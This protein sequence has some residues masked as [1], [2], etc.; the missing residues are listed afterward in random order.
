MLVVGSR[1]VVDTPGLGRPSETASS[2]NRC[3]QVWFVS[4]IFATK[5][6]LRRVSG[7]VSVPGSVYVLAPHPPAALP[8]SFL[9][10]PRVAAGVYGLYRC[11]PDRCRLGRDGRR[12]R[13][14]T[15]TKVYCQRSAPVWVSWT[16][17][18]VLQ[19]PKSA[20]LSASCC[21]WCCRQLDHLGML[22]V[23]G[24]SSR[25]SYRVVRT[26][27]SLAAVHQKHRSASHRSHHLSQSEC[28]RF[29]GLRAVAQDSA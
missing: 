18:R 1:A 20:V 25:D 10:Q 16:G 13:K 28:S 6:G 2:M 12:T 27:I 26:Q 17:A 11:S 15:T 9:W 21:C 7:R 5:K 8:F 29:Q 4:L 3:V 23:P 14:R 24:M 19:E 22:Q